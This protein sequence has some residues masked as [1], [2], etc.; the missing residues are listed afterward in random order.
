MEGPWRFMHWFRVL[1]KKNIS[2]TNYLWTL[3]SSLS[4]YCYVLCTNVN[5]IQHLAFADYQPYG[6][7]PLFHSLKISAHGW[8]INTN[9][10]W[11]AAFALINT[12]QSVSYLF[13]VLQEFQFVGFDVILHPHYITDGA[14]LKLFLRGAT[15]TEDSVI[16]FN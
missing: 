5:T 4:N 6:K 3:Q 13:S 7:L 11:T 1:Q 8:N 10:F 14:L 12:L 2:N 9:L 16:T 15:L